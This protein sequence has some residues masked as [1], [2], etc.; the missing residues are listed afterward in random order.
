MVVIYALGINIIE[1][2]FTSFYEVVGNGK[3]HSGGSMDLCKLVWV[4]RE[5]FVG[6]GAEECRLNGDQGMSKIEMLRSVWHSGEWGRGR[7]LFPLLLI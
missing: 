7:V 4:V 5:S 6:L 1:L 2:I 3:A